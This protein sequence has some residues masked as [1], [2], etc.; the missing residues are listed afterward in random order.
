MP[1]AIESS[2]RQLLRGD[3]LLELK[4]PTLH[5][6]SLLSPVTIATVGGA[7]SERASVRTEQRE[8]SPCAFRYRVSRRAPLSRSQSFTI[9]SRLPDASNRPVGAAYLPFG[10]GSIMD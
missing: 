7:C 9:P 6:S 3:N 5:K 10:D 1:F 2:Y 4:A 8:L